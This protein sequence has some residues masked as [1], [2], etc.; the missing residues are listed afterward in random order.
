VP[1]TPHGLLSCPNVHCTAT[2]V[3]LPP[4]GSTLS[5]TIRQQMLSWA[6][7]SAHPGEESTGM[8][9]RPSAWLTELVE[10]VAGGRALQRHLL[11]TS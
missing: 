4:W 5:G 10:G 7:E 2:S 6:I 9:H 3:L 8:G 1:Q 11:T